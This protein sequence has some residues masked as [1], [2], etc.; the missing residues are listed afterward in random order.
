MCIYYHFKYQYHYNSFFRFN[1]NIN[2]KESF[3]HNIF[4]YRDSGSCKH[5][6]ALLF[7]VND[8]CSRY[9]DRGAGVGTDIECVWDKPKTQSTILK[10]QGLK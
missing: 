2:N 8:F 9:K 7:G 4:Y 6:V 5:C 1:I 3:V 10:V